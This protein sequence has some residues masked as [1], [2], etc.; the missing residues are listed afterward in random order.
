MQLLSKL[1]FYV[2]GGNNV[3]E[4]VGYHDK[5]ILVEVFDWIK[6]LGKVFKKI[7][8]ILSYQH[9]KFD[10][11]N[12]GF[13]CCY[14][15]IDDSQP[16]VVKMLKEPLQQAHTYLTTTSPEE[17]TPDGLSEQR[18]QYLFNQIREFCKPGTEDYVAP[19]P[20]NKK[21]KK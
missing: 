12:P 5:R 21:P 14:K 2:S 7:D 11:N 6:W 1:C 3:A 9:F 15:T 8:N 17:T 16:V 4:L 18:Q 20:T 19:P 10:S 13:V